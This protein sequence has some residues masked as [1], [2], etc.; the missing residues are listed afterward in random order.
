MPRATQKP[1]DESQRTPQNLRGLRD[2]PFE[3]PQV[4][5]T[6][7]RR[8]RRLLDQLAEAYPDAHCELN[9]SEPHELLIATILSAQCTDVAVNK[10]TPNLFG[11]FPTPF[12]YAQASPEL[13]E[14]FIRS[15][16]LF[17][18]KAKAI[19]A[20][21]TSIVDQ[22][23]GHVP[24]TMDDLVGLRGVARKTANVVLGNAFGVNV[25]VVVDTHVSRLAVRLGLVDEGTSI[26]MIE[27]R[28]MALLPRDHWCAASHLLIFH[29]RQACTAR[30][31]RCADHQICQRFGKSCERRGG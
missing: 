5:P 23:D 10:S 13:I 19:H 26:Q 31:S 15:L 2:L 16:G 28:L 18:N 29:G 22:F 6:E 12:D 30:G 17:R 21:M 9:Y 3:L 24:Q 25:G 11:Q 8:A 1:P 14:P 7:K 27:R 4:T 20:S